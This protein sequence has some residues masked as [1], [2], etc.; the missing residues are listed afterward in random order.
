[1]KRKKIQTMFRQGDIC[2]ERIEDKRPA[3]AKPQKGPP[4]FAHGEVTGHCH[5]VE[6][7]KTK[8]FDI[9]N[10]I[11]GDQRMVSLKFAEVKTDT[12]L[13]HQEHAPIALERGN[14]RVIR[15]REYSPAAIRSV[16]D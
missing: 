3:E 12:R 13:V 8:V 7:S 14:Y 4:I 10:N 1:M 11:G 5:Q 2:I 9:D 6:D 16:A 15:Q